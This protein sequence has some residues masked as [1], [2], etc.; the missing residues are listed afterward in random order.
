MEEMSEEI[1]LAERIAEA[2]KPPRCPECGSKLDYLLYVE[3]AL[4]T[5]KFY[6]DDYHSWDTVAVQDSWY[7]CPECEKI[8][9]RDRELANKFLR[10]E[11]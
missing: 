10:G 4:N 5:A 3:E 11:E 8:L 1:D 7:E 6:G 9:F 2:L